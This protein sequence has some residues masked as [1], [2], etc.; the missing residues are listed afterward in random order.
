MGKRKFSVKTPNI[1]FLVENSEFKLKIFCLVV[2]LAKSVWKWN[3]LKYYNQTLVI[4][5]SETF[6]NFKKNDLV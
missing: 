5:V 4:L 1:K 6:K 3:V 2:M